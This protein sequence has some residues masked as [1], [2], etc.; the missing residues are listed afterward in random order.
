VTGTALGLALLMAGGGLLVVPEKTRSPTISSRSAR[1]DGPARP[2]RRAVLVCS[3]AGLAGLSLAPTW[4]WLVLPAAGLL[5]VLLVRGSPGR[6]PARRATDRRLVAVYAELLASCLDTGMAVAPALRAVSAVLAGAG[7]PGGPSGIAGRST[8]DSAGP[9]S[10]EGTGPLG[11]LDSVAAMLLLGADPRTAW[12]IADV[13]ELV[14][15]LAAAA[16]RSAAGGG[17]LADAVREHAAQLREEIAA[18]SVRS[19][20]RAGVLI[21]APLGVCFLPAF[22]CLGLAPVVVGLLGQLNIF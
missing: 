5:G 9:P 15:P 6:S 22:L 14:A 21:T 7:P 2:I 17:G 3:A 8:P 1:P 16:R 11:I 12:R 19:A 20:G 4:W 10:G 18:A 13:D